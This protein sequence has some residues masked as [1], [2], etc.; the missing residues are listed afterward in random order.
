MSDF[1]P[2]DHTFALFSA[3]LLVVIRYTAI[4]NEYNPIPTAALNSPLRFPSPVSTAS[5]L[6]VTLRRASPTELIRTEAGRE[7]IP[8]LCNNL[9][10]WG[11]AGSGREFQ[12]GVDICMSLANSY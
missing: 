12:E 1:L 7:L 11:K 8:E 6:G 4:K 5:L 10:G 3:P 9:E 2:T